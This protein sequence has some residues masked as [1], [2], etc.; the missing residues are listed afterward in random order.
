LAPWRPT[1]AQEARVIELVLSYVTR[2]TRCARMLLDAAGD[3][4]GD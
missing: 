2:D 4:Y 1:A 3:A